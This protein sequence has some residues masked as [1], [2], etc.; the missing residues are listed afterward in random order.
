[1]VKDFSGRLRSVRCFAA[2][3][4][5][6]PDWTRKMWGALV[7][8]DRPPLRGNQ[9]H[10]SSETKTKLLAHADELK[11]FGVTLEMSEPLEK[12]SDQIG[13][14]TADLICLSLA[15][16]DSLHHGILRSL[17][18]FLRDLAIPEEQIIRLRLDEPETI[19]EILQE[20]TPA[21]KKPSR[22]AR[23][24]QPAKSSKKKQS[25]KTAKKQPV[26]SAKKRPAKRSKR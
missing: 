26:K 20:P 21:A 14:T 3:S 1:M 4:A 18:L 19:S 10:V 15:V 13:F 9:V 24:K 2:P 11:R 17:I 22:P 5:E 23:R 25:A 6:V 16:G 8:A 7:V 12:I